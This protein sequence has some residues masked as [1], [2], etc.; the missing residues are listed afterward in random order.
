MLTQAMDRRPEM[1]F[2]SYDRFFPSQDTMPKGGFGNLIALP[3][4]KNPRSKGNTL[5]VDGDFNPYS[6][7]WA[8]LSSVQR[9]SLLEV[10]AVVDRSTDMGGVLGVRFVSTDEDE[11]PPWLYS[12]SGRRPKTS[13]TGPLPDDVELVLSNQIYIAKKGLPPALKNKLI[14][15][16]AF[17]NPEFYKSQAMRFPTYDK[18]R[19][20]HC[21]EDFPKH[22]GLPRGCLEDTIDLLSSLKI[23]TCIN[24]QRFAGNKLNVEFTGVLHPEQ[25]EAADAILAHSTGVLSAATA[26]G[27]TVVAAYLIAKRSVN[28]LV[29]V[30][31]KQ[32]LDQWIT[33]LKTFLNVSEGDIGQ[34]GG[35][36]R[37][38]TGIIDVAMIQ[39]LS[40]KGVVDDIV[41][42]YGYLIVDECHHISARSFEIVAR[43]TKAKYVTG[44]SAT[45]IRKDGHHPIIFMNCGPVRH[46]VDDKKQAAKRPFTH[47]VN[48]RKTKYRPPSSF[49]LKGYTAIHQIYDFLI[50][51]D[52]RNQLIL[53]D[54]LKTISDGRFPVVITERKTHLEKLKIMLMEKIENV[55]V[56]KGGMGVKQRQKAMNTLEN[57]SNSRKKVVLAT[58]RYL[59]EGFD[60][61]RLDTL[62]L[63]LP[64]S[65]RG[66]LAQYA[67]RLH[68]THY[69]KKKVM[70][71]DY[72]DVEVPMLVRMYKR[73]LTGYRAIGYEVE[74]QI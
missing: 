26:F 36:K 33:R 68:R 58:G 51:S 61:E 25:K 11:S 46:K 14:R 7:Q 24:D 59:G 48:A 10:Q 12:P 6:D 71:F 45:V 9:M 39:S 41:A 63:T 54:I 43:Q 28:T 30:H 52:D 60:D 3:L 31:R 56:M 16:A 13:I 4:Q 18:P 5:F 23:K 72:L 20:V 55:I 44:L 62:F 47:K 37:K 21:C 35:G 15:L 8:Y 2:E 34:I 38:P 65:W 42:D 17:Q 57:V 27:K 67:G 1:G 40:R 19:I 66:T 22:I 49:D 73:R 74:E 50:H 32:L 53:K 64:I 70:I 29:L 69:S